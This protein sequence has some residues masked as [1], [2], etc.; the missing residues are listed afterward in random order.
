LTI[1]LKKSHFCF[2]E[3]R[4]LGFVIGG[5]I[6]KTD[7]GKLE[8]IKNMPIPRSAKEVRPFL[9]TA[10]CFRRFVQNFAETAPLTDTIKKGKNFEMTKEA[11][12]A[13]G[14]LQEALMTAPVLRHPDFSKI[15]V[16]VDHFSKLVFLK[17]MK[18]T[19][20]AAVKFLTK[21][22]FNTLGR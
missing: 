5:G 19:T 16:V 8:A 7:P 13:I 18:E 17:A 12:E 2:K 1:G 9:G 10:G 6:L 11:K 3:L 21:E 4:F 15:N 20:T 14:Q 22:V